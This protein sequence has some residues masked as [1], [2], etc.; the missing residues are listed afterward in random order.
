V[1]WFLEYRRGLKQLLIAVGITAAVGVLLSMP[2]L[3]LYPTTY[4]Q[5]LTAGLGSYWFYDELPA[6]THPIPVSMLAFFWSEP[7]KAIVF[8]L[9]YHGIPFFIVLM[10]MWVISYM[11]SEQPPSAYREQLILVALLLSL[12]VH[13]FLS[14]GIFKFYLGAMLPFLIFFGAILKGPLVPVQRVSCPVQS[15][16]AKYMVALPPWILDII[17]RFQILSMGLVNNITTWWFVLVGLASISIFAV[18]RYLTHAILL[19]LFLLVLLFALFKHGWKWQKQRKSRNQKQTGP[20][21]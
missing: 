18:H 6:V 21:E 15:R 5:A 20:Q 19:A 2:Y 4:I 10:F 1:I 13:I 12:G 16:G 7:F 8:N 11:I 14:R 9:V 17:H 3:L